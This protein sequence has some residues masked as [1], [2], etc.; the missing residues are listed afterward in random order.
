MEDGAPE[1][2]DNKPLGA[3][4]LHGDH[5]VTKKKRRKKS[6]SAKAWMDAPISPGSWK[7]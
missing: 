5:G 7:F 4:S 1:G 3:G 6:S 2:K